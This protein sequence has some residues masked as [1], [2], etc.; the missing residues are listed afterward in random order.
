[1]TMNLN[2]YYSSFLCKIIILVQ[3]TYSFI[4]FIT[5]KSHVFTFVN[6]V[7]INYLRFN[8]GSRI[9]LHHEISSQFKLF[10]EYN[11]AGGKDYCEK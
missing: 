5:I 1:M 11:L 8:S 9:I 6:V 10:F 7:I 2:C 4:I 3:Y